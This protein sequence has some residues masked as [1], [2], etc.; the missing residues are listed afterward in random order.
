MQ[1]TTRRPSPRTRQILLKPHAKNKWHDAGLLLQPNDFAVSQQKQT[2]TRFSRILHSFGLAPHPIPMTHLQIILTLKLESYR[3]KGREKIP[4]IQQRMEITVPH[5]KWQERGQDH[6][7]PSNRAGC[8]GLS[9][10]QHASSFPALIVM[11]GIQGSGRTTNIIQ[12]WH[13]TDN[14]DD[15]ALGSRWTQ[16]EMQG[17]IP[18]PRSGH[19][20]ILYGNQMWIYGG[21]GGGCFYDDWYVYDIPNHV[22]HR[23]N[24]L[25]SSTSFS[26]DGCSSTTQRF[27]AGRRGHTATY[28]QDDKVVII[29]GMG[30]SS[31]GHTHRYFNSVHVF[32]LS[33]GIWEADLYVEEETHQK[34]NDIPSPR[35]QHTAVKLPNTSII[36]VFGGRTGPSE[37]G[38]KF[39][40][41]QIDSFCDNHLYFLD[42]SLSTVQW[43]RDRRNQQQTTQSLWYRPE[44][45]G[46]RPRARAGH[47]MVAMNNVLLLFGGCTCTTTL[48]PDRE[49]GKEFEEYDP[50]VHLFFYHA[51]YWST[52]IFTGPS[53]NGRHQ[54][55]MTLNSEPSDSRPKIWVY[56]GMNETGFCDGTVHELVLPAEVEVNDDIGS[57][58]VHAPEK[59]ETTTKPTTTIV[60]QRNGIVTRASP[61]HRR[62]AA[63]SY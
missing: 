50:R 51:M 62:L 7:K 5:M 39:R 10:E 54:H 41:G 27:P 2:I 11:G 1:N 25:C 12:E 37:E 63:H 31:A 26:G 28:L 46:I 18:A 56:G 35:A 6:P 57:D 20:A 14:D 16:H 9:Y 45:S 8:V 36:C 15:N 55:L 21:Q 34:N 23:S 49:T 24:M 40:Q 30:L 58:V 53:P 29:G 38:S 60:P 22:W 3:N 33:S 44:V 47:A 43:N 13:Y 59:K 42:L 32:H 61:L 48:Y 17:D 52:C 4:A 19:S